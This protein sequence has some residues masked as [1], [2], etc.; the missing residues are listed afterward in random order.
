LDLIRIEK[1]TTFSRSLRGRPQKKRDAITRA[2]VAKA[3]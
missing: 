3:E 2:F 1:F